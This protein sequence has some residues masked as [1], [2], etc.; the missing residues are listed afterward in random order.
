MSDVR[1]PNNDDDPLTILR[2]KY[3][4][5]PR[6]SGVREDVDL[7][8]ANRMINLHSYN[9]ASRMGLLLT[10]DPGAGKTSL[11][12]RLVSRHPALQSGGEGDLGALVLRVESPVTLKSLA[13]QI[14][15]ALEFPVQ[16]VATRADYWVDARFHLKENG[17][18]LLWLDEAQH[19]FETASDRHSVEIISTLKNMMADA[20]WPIVLVLSGPPQLE[21]YCMLDRQL[22]RRL[23]KR[24]LDPITAA[25]HGVQVERQLREYCSI[26]GLSQAL[27]SGFV[28]RLLHATS[29]NLGMTFELI[30][31]AIQQ[32]LF[33]RSTRLLIDHFAR[34]YLRQ[35]D[36]PTSLNIFLVDD[37]R[38]I[39]V[40][41]PVEARP[42]PKSKSKKTR[43]EG[44]W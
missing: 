31:D 7:L 27:P 41:A 42:N 14:L 37:W 1:P 26:A 33:V 13:L 40:G 35:N 30:V 32:A 44:I 18:R 28:E 20:N 8:L 22:K 21:H 6:D 4:E 29:G 23:F 3:V 36:C 24:R 38:S 17:V 15:R 25:A 39:S 9:P 43:R 11:L 2:G 5:S 16:G 12:N 19:V 10:G 34:A